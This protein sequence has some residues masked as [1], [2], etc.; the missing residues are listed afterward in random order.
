MTYFKTST[1]CYTFLTFLPQ[2]F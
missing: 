2:T 1:A